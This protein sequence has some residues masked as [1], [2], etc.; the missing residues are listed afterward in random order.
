MTDPEF[1]FRDRNGEIGDIFPGA[2]PEVLCRQ[3]AGLVRGQEHRRGSPAAPMGVI[4]P[5]SQNGGNIAP[6]SKQALRIV[7]LKGQRASHSNGF[8]IFCPHDGAGAAPGGRAANIADDAGEAHP[9]FACRS[10]GQEVIVRAQFS[11]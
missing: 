6:Q 10:D 4:A 5:G 3:H 7:R 2:F 11:G 1:A 9:V 8:E